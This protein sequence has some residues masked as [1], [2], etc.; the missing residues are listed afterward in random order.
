VSPEIATAHGY[1]RLYAARGEGLHPITHRLRLRCIAVCEVAM[2]PKVRDNGWCLV[3]PDAQL[4]VPRFLIVWPIAQP[5]PS[6]DGCKAAK[7]EAWCRS[8]MAEF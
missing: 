4:I 2:S 5:C 8:R 6:H 1:S 7:V 3:V